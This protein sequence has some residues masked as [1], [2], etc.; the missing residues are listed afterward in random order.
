MTC[1]D[2]IH[3]KDHP[4]SPYFSKTGAC[5]DNWMLVEEYAPP[6]QAFQKVGGKEGN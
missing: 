2:C 4:I 6:C 5:D 1:G 3:F